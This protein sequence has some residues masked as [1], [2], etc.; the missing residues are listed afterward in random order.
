[1]DVPL[2]TSMGPYRG[3][4]Q[5]KRLALAHAAA[6]GGDVDLVKGKRVTVAATPWKFEHGGAC[7]VRMI[8]M[9]DP[10]GNLRID[11]GI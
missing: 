3:G 11:A 9:M 6:T 5:T 4:P 2:A 10:S 8:A 7:P 1:M